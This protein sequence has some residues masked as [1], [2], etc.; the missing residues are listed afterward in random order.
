MDCVKK[1]IDCDC[2]LNKLGVALWR[3]VAEDRQQ[4]RGSVEAFKTLLG[5]LRL[6]GD[7]VST[8]VK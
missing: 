8:T 4:W 5:F 6:S 7:W 1:C 3:T 2:E